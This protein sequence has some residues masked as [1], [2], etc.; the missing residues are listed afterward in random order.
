M[1]TVELSTEEKMKQYFKPVDVDFIGRTIYELQE[2]GLYTGT[3][4][5]EVV[6]EGETGC[7]RIISHTGRTISG[8]CQISRKGKLFYA[9][10]YVWGLFN[11]MQ[12]PEGLQINHACDVP[13]C[14]NPLHLQL[15][16]QAD[17]M[18]EKAERGRA[19]KGDNHS[20]SKITN[21]ET[22]LVLVAD[23]TQKAIGEKFGVSQM[24]VGDIRNGSPKAGAHRN[25]IHAVLNDN[26]PVLPRIPLEQIEYARPWAEQ[27][28]SIYVK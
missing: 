14:V 28:A 20:S 13:T 15:G 27:I 25:N 4:P 12:I 18:R 11:G 2:E 6:E 16:T 3:M 21:A 1:E 9:H 22:L 10:R 7:Y 23:G 8:H 24:Q 19:P 5:L 17:N 26:L